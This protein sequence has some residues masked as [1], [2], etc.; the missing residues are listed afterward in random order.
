M[1]LLYIK[2]IMFLCNVI[3][4]FFFNRQLNSFAGLQENS[5]NHSNFFVN[6]KSCLFR[7]LK[8]VYDVAN[9]CDV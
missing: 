5:S 3:I 4:T 9:K 7:Q 8:Q 1:Y 2:F 6:C